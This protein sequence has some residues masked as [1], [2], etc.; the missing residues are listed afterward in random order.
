MEEVFMLLQVLQR[1]YGTPS[2]GTDE[3]DVLVYCF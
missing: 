3:H 1:G 2:G